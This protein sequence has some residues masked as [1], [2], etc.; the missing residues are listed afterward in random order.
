MRNPPL[1]AFLLALVAPSALSPDWARDAAQVAVLAVAPLG[2]FALGVNLMQEQEDG[3]RV[4][5]P[6]LTAPVATAVGLRLVVAPSVMAL[7][8]ADARD[9]AAGRSSSSPGWRAGSTASRSRT[10]TGSTCGSPPA[11]IAWSTAIVLV[12]ASIVAAFGGL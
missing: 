11:P 6:P 4:F 2:F 1:F 3:V 5:P 8:V 7:A 12:A 9:G 10:S